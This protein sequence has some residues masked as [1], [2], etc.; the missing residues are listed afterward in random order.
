MIRIMEKHIGGRL[1][2]N[3]RAANVAEGLAFQMLRPVAA[4]SPVPREED[5]G[6]DAIGTLIRRTGRVYVA[7]DSFCVQIKTRTSANF[8]LSGDGIKWLRELSLPYFPVVVD[9]RSATLSLFTVNHHRLAFARDV[10]VSS[11]N[12]TLDGSGPDDFPLGDPLLTWSVDEAADPDFPSWAHSVLKP[13]IRVEAWNQHF[14]PARSIRILNYETQLFRARKADGTAAFPP[15][16]G[17][18]LHIPPGDGEFIR[19][20]V[21]DILEPFAAWISNASR[22]AHQGDELLKIRDALRRLNLDPD[23]SNK[24]DEIAADMSAHAESKRVKT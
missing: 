21:T 3:F 13:A 12:F 8:P 5:Y 10:L 9:L 1:A 23:P 24:W 22:H 18:L 6:I 16:P 19:K 11:M 2:A 7:E 4:L 14:A 20:T 15:T 17:D